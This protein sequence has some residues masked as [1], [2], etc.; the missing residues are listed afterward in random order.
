M[1]LN[2]LQ[3]MK[4]TGWVSSLAVPWPTAI[5]SSTPRKSSFDCI[6]FCFFFWAANVLLL[7]AK[8]AKQHKDGLKKEKKEIK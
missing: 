2:A 3:F 5:L 4:S 8:L 7:P 1:D 6:A